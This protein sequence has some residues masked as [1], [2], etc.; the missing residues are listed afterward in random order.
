MQNDHTT[1]F[2]TAEFVNSWCRA[3]GDYEPVAIQVLGSGPPRTMHVVKTPMRYAS[4]K[5][6]GP[7]AHDLWTSPGWTG[8]LSRLT[9]EAI[10]RQLTGVRTRS[11]RWQVRFD[12]EP[13]AII[14][15]SLGLIH[16]RVK[17]HVLKLDRDYDDLFGQ[18]NATTR[19]HVRKAARRG[20]TV[21]STCDVDDILAYQNIYSK[22]AQNKSWGFE[23][24]AQ[25][26]LE[27]VQMPG[28]ACFKVAQYNNGI[29]G[30]ALFV[31]DGIPF[32]TCMGW[33]TEIVAIFSQPVPFLMLEFNGLARAAQNSSI[34]AIRA[35]VLLANR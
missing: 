18:Y 33:R 11:I 28:K 8:E 17:I 30:G 12:H 26:T 13:L 22:H 31:R 15:T 6:S 7:R 10:L 9:V 34:L 24:P 23:Y 35:L 32:I 5:I 20:V 14:L 3:F 27:L 29:I 19:N 2:S 4:C 16:S 21:R 1:I 25:M